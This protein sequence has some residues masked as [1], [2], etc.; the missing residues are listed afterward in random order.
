MA[1]CGLCVI[2][3][4][5]LVVDFHLVCLFVCLCVCVCVSRVMAC[6][7]LCVIYFEA[8]VVDFHLVCLFVCLCVCVCVCVACYG[9]L[10]PM[11][12]LFRGTC[13]RLSP[14]VFVCLF[15]CVC[16]CVCVSRVMACCGLC[17]IYFEAL[18]V[19]FHLV[20]LFVCLCVCVCVCVCR[21][22][23]RVVAYV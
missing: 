4:E 11:C 13:R 21:V 9:V 15:M 12:N 1:C 5:A 22:L 20:C 8:L 23:W 14:G 18:V 2:Y 3:F 10:W 7:G 16:V 6:C 19:D 17:V